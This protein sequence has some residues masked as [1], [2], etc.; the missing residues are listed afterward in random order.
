MRSAVRVAPRLPVGRC[1]RVRRQPRGYGLFRGRVPALHQSGV[2][3]ILPSLLVGTYSRAAWTTTRWRN[4]W[5][6]SSSRHNAR[7][8]TARAGP[9]RANPAS[10]PAAPMAL[11]ASAGLPL[12]DAGPPATVLPRALRPADRTRTALRRR[13][14]PARALLWP[15][16][17]ASPYRPS[18]SATSSV[19]SLLLLPSNAPAPSP[20]SHS[21][22]PALRVPAALLGAP[23]IL[24]WMDG[25]R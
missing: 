11:P 14:R 21:R 12:P 25:H 10:G 2:P 23:R 16:S 3:P 13:L 18:S 5:P 7:A 24:P 9:S 4:K 1:L 6:S 19:T 8:H 22:P 17:S 20:V 15:P